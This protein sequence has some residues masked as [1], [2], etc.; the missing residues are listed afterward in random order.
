MAK[1][2]IERLTRRERE[3]MNVGLTRHYDVDLRWET[4]PIEIF[5][6]MLPY[7]GPDVKTE[8]R[9]RLG[10][11]V[12]SMKGKIRTFVVDHIDRVPTEH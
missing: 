5:P 9:N 12:E 8:F 2:T 11:Q 7:D 10:L 1:M 3:I 4:P 6:D